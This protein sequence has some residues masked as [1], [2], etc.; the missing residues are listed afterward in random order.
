MHELVVAATDLPAD[1]LPR[2]ANGT[3]DVENPGFRL[4][5]EAEGIDMGDHAGL[6]VRLRPGHYVM[7]CNMQGHYEAGMAADVTVV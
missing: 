3:V 1:K 5:G 4:L 6:T 7:F 2:L